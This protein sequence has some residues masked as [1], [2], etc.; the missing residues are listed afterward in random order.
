MFLLRFKSQAELCLLPGEVLLYY[1]FLP[2]GR[3]LGGEPSLIQGEPAATS[4]PMNSPIKFLA[5]NFSTMK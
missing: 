2:L 1:C 4:H 5:S 3:I